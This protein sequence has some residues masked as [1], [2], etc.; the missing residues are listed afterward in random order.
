MYVGKKINDRY[1]VIDTIG[2]GGMANVFLAHDLILDRD[3]AVKILRYDFREDSDVIRRFQR[4]AQAA[5]T[6]VHPNIV[7]VYD[8]GEEQNLHYIVMEYVKGTDL[9]KYIQRSFP[10]PYQKVI[11][12]MGQILSAV[13]HAHRNKIIHRDLKPQNILID[14]E[15][16]VKITDF[17]IAVALSE[18]S[19]TQ[20]NSLLGSVHYMSPEQAKGGLATNQSDIYAL[21]IILYELLT[22][23]VPF[24]G[25]SAVSIALKHF[26]EE[27]PSVREFD[28]RIPQP[29]ENVV[30]KA[31]TKDPIDRYSSVA[32]MWAD[33]A[34]ALS[35][36]RIDE[37]KFVPTASLDET[38]VLTPITPPETVEAAEDELVENETSKVLD[39]DTKDP[40]K[41]NKKKRKKW[42]YITA[43][44]IVLALIGV[45]VALALSAPK[46]V[47]VPDVTGMTEVEAREALE[48]AKLK[49]GSVTQQPSDEVEKDKII[50]T[51]PK[52][53]RSVKEKT[54]VNLY[55]S[56]GKDKVKIEDYVGD[57]YEEVKAKL[58]KAGYTVTKE[59]VE[60][61][62]IEAG[63]IISQDP[64]AGTAVV[65]K[66]TTI[67]FTVSAGPASFTLRDLTQYT[68]KSVEDY[69][70]ENG[71]VLSVEEEYS[72]TVEAGL[73][74]SQNPGADKSVYPGS[75]LTVTIS[76]GPKEEPTKEITRTVTIPYVADTTPIDSSADSSATEPEKK[77]NKI[78]I[79]IEDETHD[80]A[81][82]A[83]SF[84]LTADRPYT[85]TFKIKVGSAAKYKVYRDGNLILSDDNV[86]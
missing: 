34:T 4:E 7:A 37:P 25:E 51:D 68:R 74:I 35:T 16:N 75:A 23:R 44:V 61:D 17:G 85:F 50:K 83:D 53:G 69:A 1:K 9:K 60:H 63:K 55:V 81:G 21:G 73:V 15:G 38:K 79:Y 43:G 48:K 6:L 80:L 33:L 8:V 78:T 2:G 45:L 42:P 41:K 24:E 32:Q 65:P 14:E 71:L 40:K 49:L 22:G 64:E 18:T 27:L 36:S 72:S 39:E 28:P 58:T 29:L 70:N 54:S 84:D 77:A 82:I 19:I 59:E 76:K 52:A 62:E 20:T 67:T 86:Q 3:V 56:T 13:E 47:I 66:D 11:D 31:T 10:I 57:D 30:L 5:T 26:Q 46:D 12:I